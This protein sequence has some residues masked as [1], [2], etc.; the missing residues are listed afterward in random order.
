MNISLFCL[1]VSRHRWTWVIFIG[2]TNIKHYVQLIMFVGYDHRFNEHLT[3]ARW[4][5]KRSQKEEKRLPSLA[6]DEWVPSQTC[7]VT[8]INKNTNGDAGDW[9]PCL[10]HAKRAL[11]HLSYIPNLSYVI[12]MF[13]II[14]CILCNCSSTTKQKNQINNRDKS[15]N[16]EMRGIEP[17]FFISA[18][19]N[20]LAIELH[21]QLLRNCMI[22]LFSLC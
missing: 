22:R 13:S 18:L 17:R 7:M 10:S 4:K 3:T 20:A 2:P 14:Y 1:S 8:W 16:L 12:N 19:N 15:T 5:E 11:Y 21:P 6:D 9:T